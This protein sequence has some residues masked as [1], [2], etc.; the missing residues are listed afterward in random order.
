MGIAGPGIVAILEKNKT[1]FSLKTDTRHNFISTA[2][3]PSSM[4]AV[5]LHDA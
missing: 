2:P 5:Q 3:V 1:K 4:A